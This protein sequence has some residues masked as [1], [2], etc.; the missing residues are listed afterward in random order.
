MFVGCFT[1]P[2][3]PL[4]ERVIEFDGAG[5]RATYHTAA[6]IPAFLRI[7]QY[8]R[9]ALFRVGNE[10]IGHTYMD[11]QVAPVAQRRINYDRIRGRITVGKCIDFRFSQIISPAKLDNRNFFRFKSTVKEYP[12]FFK[13]HI[14]MNLPH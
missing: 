9:F 2:A 3:N 14:M 10:K 7:K 11:T 12:Y 6:F 13:G 8:R 4:C 5:L 1:F